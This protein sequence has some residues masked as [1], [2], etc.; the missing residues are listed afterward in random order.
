MIFNDIFIFE[1]KLFAI[2]FIILSMSL[3]FTIRA[4]SIHNPNVITNAMFGSVSI[5]FVC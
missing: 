1:R 2:K 3:K 4:M 5:S